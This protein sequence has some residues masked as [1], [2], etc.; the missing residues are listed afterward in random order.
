MFDILVV[1]TFPFFSWLLKFSLMEFNFKPN[2]TWLS[3]LGLL[4]KKSKEWGSYVK[5]KQRKKKLVAAA[6]KYTPL[7]L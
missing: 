2:M 5:V 4:I 7:S 3:D 6:L 1:M